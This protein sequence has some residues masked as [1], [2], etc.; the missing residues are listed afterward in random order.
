M[1]AE[2]GTGRAT[3]ISQQHSWG[4]QTANAGLVFRSISGV[5]EL[6]PPI[7][8]LR[9]GRLLDTKAL[10]VNSGALSMR[11]QHFT[12]LPAACRWYAGHGMEGC[13]KAPSLGME[14]REWAA[15]ESAREMPGRSLK[16][17]DGSCPSASRDEVSCG[18]VR[19]M[20]GTPSGR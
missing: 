6:N 18:V 9:P 15:R 17:G 19:R 7:I 14:P 10:L 11:Y 8:E 1:S 16:E 5:W 3:Y 13:G 20:L 12:I 4:A 2:V